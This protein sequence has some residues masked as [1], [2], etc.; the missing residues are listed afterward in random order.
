MTIRICLPAKLRGNV[1]TNQLNT[2][3][4]L[5][6]LRIDFFMRIVQGLLFLFAMVLAANGPAAAAGENAIPVVVELFT[7]EACSSCP[8]AD[9]LLTKLSEQRVVNGA[10]VFVLG[11]HVDYF[12]HL[13]W[14]DRFSSAAFTERQYG[15][16]KRFHLSS[17]Y[18]PQMVVD[19]R[20]EGL[21][22]DAASVEREI[23]AAAHS[24]KTA[25]VSLKWTAQN[26]LR[27]TV[28]GAPG[29]SSAVL[30]AITE[31]RL[32]TSVAD[33]ENSGR[34]LRHSGVV[35]QLRQIGMTSGSVFAGTAP[36]ALA[37][38]WKTRDL[39]IVVFVQRPGNREIIGAAA[40]KF[41]CGVPAESCGGYTG[42]A[43]EV[44]NPRLPILSER[45][46]RPRLVQNV[47]A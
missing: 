18:T 4:L 17:V 10:E 31:D 11:E 16:A 33:G 46:L 35:R 1:F 32:T 47:L 7:S 40:V 24:G 5:S 29:E 3:Q 44:S 21:G 12:N 19:G 9:A 26:A 20:F 28:A 6:G 39:Q 25:S 36:I 27:V 43:S 38:S 14:T 30:L 37:A 42:W 22:S 8:P 34:V 23:G 15:Y 13:G 2:M 45:N 41:P